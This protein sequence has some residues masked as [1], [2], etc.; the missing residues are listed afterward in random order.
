MQNVLEFF[1]VS[2]EQRRRSAWLT[3][4]ALLALW[5]HHH[6]SRR[7]LATLTARELADIGIGDAERWAECRKHFWQA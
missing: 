1:F 7:Q 3:L 6:H 2:A 4:W 5:H